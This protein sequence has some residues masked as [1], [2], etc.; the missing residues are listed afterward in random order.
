M[1]GLSIRCPLS[2]SPYYQLLRFWRSTV[3][4]PFCTKSCLST[5]P[6]TRDA[7]FIPATVLPAIPLNV[8]VT[9]RWGPINISS[10]PSRAQE[11]TTTTSDPF[12]GLAVRA[13]VGLLGLFDGEH[14]QQPDLGLRGR[15]RRPNV[16]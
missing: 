11:P 8:D 16:S 12:S 15:D 5:C 2:V 10:S 13:C 1:A 6:S 9:T 4:S 3:K 14:R 7:V